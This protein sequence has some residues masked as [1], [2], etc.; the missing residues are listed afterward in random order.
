MGIGIGMGI[1]L[2]PSSLEQWQLQMMSIE[3]HESTRNCCDTIWYMRLG[4]NYD[5]NRL[6]GGHMPTGSDRKVNA[7]PKFDANH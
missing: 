7:F 1:L 2:S 3:H 6:L 4:Y 5:Q